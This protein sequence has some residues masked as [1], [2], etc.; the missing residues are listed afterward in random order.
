MKPLA[1]LAAFA[2]FVTI[3][4]ATIA[5]ETEVQWQGTSSGAVELS[6]GQGFD[7]DF[8]DLRQSPQDFQ[9]D[10]AGDGLYWTPYRVRPGIGCSA[11]LAPGDFT[12]FDIA[13]AESLT[14]SLDRIYLCGGSA[15]PLPAGATLLVATCDGSFS[16]VS[17]DSCGET[18][19]IHYAT[20]HKRIVAKAPVPGSLPAPAVKSPPDGVTFDHEPRDLLLAWGA[21]PGASKYD[22]ELDCKGCCGPRREFFCADQENGKVFQAKPG[23]TTPAYY[24]IWLGAYPGRWRVRA[25]KPDGTPG[26]WSGWTRFAFSK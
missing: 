26:P 12:S 20:F 11:A 4:P 3:A 8:G 10:R 19:K 24:T 16:K 5:Q 6:P 7:L 21:V 22:L 23:L 25:F 2:A 1:A 15:P 18:L 17:I 13:T 9:F 14:V